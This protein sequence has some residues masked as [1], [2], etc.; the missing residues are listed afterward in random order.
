MN[1][2]TSLT[3]YSTICASVCLTS[4]CIMFGGRT[5]NPH[6]FVKDSPSTR[7]SINDDM[8]AGGSDLSELIRIPVDM[9]G[10]PAGRVEDLVDIGGDAVEDSDGL[11]DAGGDAVI[12]GGAD[13][14]DAGST[15]TVRGDDTGPSIASNPYG[16]GT[17]AQNSPDPTGSQRIRYKTKYASNSK[18][19]PEHG[20]AVYLTPA[21]RWTPLTAT[22]TDSAGDKQDLRI[23]RWNGGT[24][25]WGVNGNRVHLRVS[26]RLASGPASIE[27][28][29]PV[30][31]A[32]KLVETFN[33]PNAHAAI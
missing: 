11:V 31:L 15:D 8:E 27:V 28:T 33:I 7:I 19:R 32:D 10:I 24:G 3:V 17:I 23:T 25:E 5:Q 18:N 14:D 13:G 26:K 2:A 12:S 29:Y 30:G 22:L 9:G 6:I 1:K 20:V 16:R 4:G 21:N